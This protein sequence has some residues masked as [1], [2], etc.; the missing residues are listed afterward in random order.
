MN[1][2]ISTKPQSA[3]LANKRHPKTTMI[4]P[5]DVESSQLSRWING[6]SDLASDIQL[7]G[8]KD[9]FEEESKKISQFAR[10]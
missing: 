1:T 2:K 3:S 9:Y 4:N 7:I 5:S 8:E 6:E 10:D